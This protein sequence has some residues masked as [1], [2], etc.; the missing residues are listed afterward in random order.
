MLLHDQNAYLAGKKIHIMYKT[1]VQEELQT[2]VLFVFEFL[3]K[4]YTSDQ[5]C[6][7]ET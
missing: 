1:I 2:T 4:N 5:R 6:C 3:V 7:C